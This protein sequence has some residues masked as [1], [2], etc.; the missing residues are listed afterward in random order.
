MNHTAVS[1][2]RCDSCH[3]GSYTSQ[4]TK[5]AQGT[6]S[7]PNHVAR[8]GRDCNVCHT[9]ATTTTFTS[10]AGGVYPHQPADTVCSGCHNGTT[11]PGKTAAHIPT[12]VECSNCHVNTASTFKTYT[13]NH[14]AVSASPCDSC[15]NGSYTSQ[16][17]KGAQG[18]TAAHIPTTAQ[19]NNCHTSTAA[20]FK[21]YTMN[22]TAVSA[23]RCDSCHNGSYTSQGTKGAWAPPA[24]DHPDRAGRDCGCCHTSTTTFDRRQ[25]P[26]PSC[27]TTAKAPTVTVVSTVKAVVVRSAGAVTA[28]VRDA[29]NAIMGSKPVA[30]PTAPAA[31]ATTVVARPESGPAA[32]SAGLPK[33]LAATATRPTTTETPAPV[34]GATPT[35][36]T[37]IGTPGSAAGNAA[38]GP[39]PS[40]R[41]SGLNTGLS[42]IGGSRFSHPAASSGCARCH[43]GRSGLGKPPKHVMTNAPCETCHKSTNTF[44][45][46][47]INH[48]SMTAPC[49][50]CHNGVAA[51]GKPPKHVTTSAPC[52]TCHKS[53]TTFA[54]A[55]TD[56][57]NMTAPC[58]SCHNGT[59]ARG[60]G[61]RHFTTAL[62]CDACHR[63]AT[64]TSV[65]YRHNSGLYPNHG[66]SIACISCHTTNAQ[67]VPWKFAAYKPDCAGCHAGNFKPALHI[68]SLKPVPMLYT[69][70][71]LRDCTGACHTYADRTFTTVLTRRLKAHRV[72]GGGW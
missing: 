70:A 24:G 32:P 7:Y 31:P 4:G 27:T 46:A 1:A 52:E 16:G 37:L 72:N 68:K 18:K 22:H 19:C 17:T 25:Q 8:N 9:A 71:E 64:W 45:G 29:T 11:A 63:T 62:P 6:A 39:Y 43:D 14:A 48:R 10:W 36:N 38:T 58:A 53:M 5:G 12:T 23:S 51:T 67:T 57:R 66:K 61:A 55:R 42:G 47:R 20:S 26:S 44:A 54:G 2:S 13:M 69:V 21:T 15:H 33:Q 50:S 49:A 28:V 35:A 41:S 30:A 34:A 59:T 56:H 3:N 65:I 40:I 60:K